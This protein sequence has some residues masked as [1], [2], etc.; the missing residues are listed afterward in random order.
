MQVDILGQENVLKYIEATK[1]TK[2]SILRAGAT[3]HM[4]VFECL[5]S[6]SNSQ[7][8]AD[9]KRWAEVMNNGMP[10]KIILFDFAEFS[11]NEH[12]ETIVK[13]Q[14]NRSAKC[15]AT[16]ILNSSFAASP[17][18]N[19]Q[20]HEINGGFDVKGLRE[21]IINELQKNKKKI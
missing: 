10:Y 5:D 3:A 13:K 6:D 14:K 9:F 11:Q 19:P 20:T 7:A 18:T 16:F 2:F 21:S 12:G 4:S 8:L 17:T 1:K 15:E